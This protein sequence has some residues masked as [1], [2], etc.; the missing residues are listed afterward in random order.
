MRNEDT[1]LSSIW[2]PSLDVA[3]KIKSK[4]QL[5]ELNVNDKIVWKGKIQLFYNELFV[6]HLNLSKNIIERISMYNFLV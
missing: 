1:K 3:D 2:G 6:Y 5:P 4:L